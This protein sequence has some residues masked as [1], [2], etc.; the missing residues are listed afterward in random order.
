MINYVSCVYEDELTF[1]IMKRLINLYP[2]KFAVGK[3]IPCYGF[4]KIKKNILAYNNAASIIP[5]FVITDL[6]RHECAPSLKKEWLG[7]VVPHKGFIFRVAVTEIESW[8]MSDDV[9]FSKFL[10]I[11]TDL[12][13]KTPDCLEDPKQALINLARKSRNRELR[14]GLLPADESACEGPAYNLF[15]CKFV[16]SGWNVQNACAHSPSLKRA[17][18]ALEKY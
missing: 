13:N 11:S 2:S 7:S 16:E 17:L 12:I 9:N 15:L 18:S 1:S 10:G 3:T 14:E 6:D 5:F 8:V 4:G